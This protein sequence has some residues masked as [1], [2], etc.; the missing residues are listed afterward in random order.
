M[1]RDDRDQVNPNAN[2]TASSIRDFIRINTP[3]FFGSMVEKDP[4]GFIDE[5]S[6][7]LD[8]MGVSSQE[9]AKLAAYQL[10]D[11]AYVWYDQWKDV[12]PVRKGWVTW[13]A[14]KKTFL[15]RFFHL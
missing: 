4:H 6:K 3:N 14:F 2:T 5:V 1:T 11:V 7:V 13:E 8:A 12:R 15:D 9:K 10:K